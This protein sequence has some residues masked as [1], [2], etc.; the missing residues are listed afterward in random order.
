MEKVRKF[1]SY[2]VSPKTFEMKWYH[3]VFRT[4][5]LDFKN[6]IYGYYNEVGFRLFGFTFIWKK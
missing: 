2:Y 3:W 6:T 5:N 4:F 1:Y